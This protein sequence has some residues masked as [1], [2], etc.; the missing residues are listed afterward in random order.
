MGRPPRRPS[1]PQ[2][3]SRVPQPPLGRRLLALLMLLS[4]L[5]PVLAQLL[6]LLLLLL[7]PLPHPRWP[8]CQLLLRR[9]LCQLL[10]RRPLCQLLL[11]RPL[12]QLLL[13]RPLC[14]PH[15]PRTLSLRRHRC[16]N[17]ERYFP[18]E[19]PAWDI[20]ASCAARLIFVRA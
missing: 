16:V 14:P 15:P 9:P 18:H 13:R 4:T 10:L 11:R 19:T 12:C 1:L 5:R 8:P 17:C 3:L 20:F 6:L 2:P 7:L